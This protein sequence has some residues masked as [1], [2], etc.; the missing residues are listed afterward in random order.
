MTKGIVY[1]LVILS[2]V[3][4]MWAQSHAMSAFTD[5][6]VVMTTPTIV[7]VE[8][9]DG[10]AYHFHYKDGVPAFLS[11]GAKVVIEMDIVWDDKIREHF[12]INDMEI[13]K[14][15]DIDDRTK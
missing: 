9:T 1:F 10:N 7:V 13:L 2:I 8:D 14:E 15:E 12:K 4:F 5:M 11:V 6:V 3:A